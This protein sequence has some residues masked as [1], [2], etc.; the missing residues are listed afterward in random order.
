MLDA[1][2]L[3]EDV[4]K[5]LH[6]LLVGVHVQ[7]RQVYFRHVLVEEE[8]EERQL[9]LARHQQLFLVPLLHDFSQNFLHNGVG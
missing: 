1:G 6:V 8:L 2:T 4:L 5:K 3:V 9:Q 7:L